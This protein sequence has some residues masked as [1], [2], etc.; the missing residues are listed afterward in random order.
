MSER[1]AGLVGGVAAGRPIITASVIA[2]A[3]AA[4]AAVGYRQASLA[5]SLTSI[6]FL[7]A[8]FL[9]VVAPAAAAAVAPKNFWLRLICAGFA[10]GLALAARRLLLQ[11]EIHLGPLDVGTALNFAAGGA[12]VLI[13]GAPLWRFAVGG[14]LVGL[15]AAVLGAAGAL[16]A[17]AIESRNGGVTAA[18]PSIALAS[19][20]GAALAVQLATTFARAFAE[21][22]DNY[23]A[24]GLAAR[25]ATSPALFALALG[26]AGVVA[27]AIGDG[28]SPQEALAAA[29]IAASAIAFCVAAPLF[30]LPGG[31]AL[32]A[33]TEAT[34]VSENRRRTTIRPLLV[35][36]STVLPPSSALAASALLLIGAVVAGFETTTPAS[37]GEIAVVVAAALAAGVA[38][39]SLR[40][41]LLGV[42]LLLAAS[43]L[44]MWAIDLAGLETPTE[45]ARI[46]SSIVA[47]ALFLQL[48]LAWRDRRSLRR[49]AREVVSMALADSL[50][51]YIAAGV[52]AVAALGAS[53]AAGLWSEGVE[54]A[55]LTG[56][57][58]FIGLV[59]APPLMTAV[60]ALFG[61]N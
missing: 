8:V 10:A 17:V 19:A 9:T 27:A 39:V 42:V 59:A 40:T 53:E 41:A 16:S 25:E 47:S 28:A 43:R 14:S 54:A 52:L 7:G 3:A 60:G 46:V 38:F 4:L 48:C 18:G 1:G 35:A 26:V 23:Q 15:F 24:A 36:V 13:A 12:F 31:L 55:L 57:L 58:A 45:T 51:S 20:L 50:F 34:A 56:A 32:K 61:R 30:M 21:G 29:R 37:F 22:G 6:S 33:K 44:A 2:F 5:Y 49:K 11:N